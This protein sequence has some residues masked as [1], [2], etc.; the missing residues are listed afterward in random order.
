MRRSKQDVIPNGDTVSDN[1]EDE[2]RYDES[3]PTV[4][5]HNENLHHRQQQQQREHFHNLRH[6]DVSDKIRTTTRFQNRRN[7]E[8]IQVSSASI[9]Y[10]EW[11]FHNSVICSR[12]NFLPVE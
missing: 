1:E 6:S 4:R 2:V 5:T 8:P 10:I 9:S 3:G 11:I 7:R 12:T